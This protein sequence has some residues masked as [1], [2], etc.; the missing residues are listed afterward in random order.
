MI[1]DDYYDQEITFV[2]HL[3]VYFYNKYQPIMIL[4]QNYCIQTGI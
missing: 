3:L 1:E 4:A 2:L